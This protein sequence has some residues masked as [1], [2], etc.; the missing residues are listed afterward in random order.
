[1]EIPAPAQ[2]VLAQYNRLTDKRLPD[3]IVSLH[4]IGSIALDAYRHGLSDIDFIAVVAEPPT[5]TELAGLAEI[6]ASLPETPMLDGFYITPAQLRGQAGAAPNL[7]RATEGTVEP[8]GG[9][10]S[11]IT[12]HELLQHA[13][14]LR[15]QSPSEYG[16]HVNPDDLNTWLVDNL[17]GYWAR[18]AT[19]LRTVIADRP[20]GAAANPETITWATTGPGRLHYTLTT[21]GI[22]S[23]QDSLVY[24][25]KRF[26]Q[27]DPDLLDRCLAWRNGDA[28]EFTIADGHK[29]AD[30]IDAVVT[31]VKPNR[32]PNT[33]RPIHR[34]FKRRGA[35]GAVHTRRTTSTSRRR[36]PGRHDETVYLGHLPVKVRRI[37]RFAPYRLIHPA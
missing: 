18:Y 15:G 13:I 29:A 6:H 9:E 26:P 24:S 35:T 28:G 25:K 37:K 19:D 5:E 31:S 7:V 33:A 12:R 2:D 36:S 1:M 8:V 30:H 16:L 22:V 27:T 21:G 14:T 20:L 4:I 3:V 34:R 32:L 10:P 11:A 17:T 23:K